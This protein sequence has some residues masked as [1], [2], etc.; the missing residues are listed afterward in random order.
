MEQ[1]QREKS[2]DDPF[3]QRKA[4]IPRPWLTQ[5]TNSGVDL[6]ILGERRWQFSLNKLSACCCGKKSNEN[7]TTP[8]APFSDFPLIRRD[9]RQSFNSYELYSTS[10][11]KSDGSGSVS[12]FTDSDT[13]SSYSSTSDEKTT[14]PPLVAQTAPESVS[15]KPSTIDVATR[16]TSL[17]PLN[18][19]T[20]NH[21]LPSSFQP[22]SP[23]Q[24]LDTD[25]TATSNTS[26][27]RRLE[28]FDF[29]Q[30]SLTDIWQ[31][32]GLASKLKSPPPLEVRF[33][34]DYD[35]I[36]MSERSVTSDLDDLTGFESS[37][38]GADG[39]TNDSIGDGKRRSLLEDLSLLPPRPAIRR[40]KGKKK[41]PKPIMSIPLYLRKHASLDAAVQGELMLSGWVAASLDNEAFELTLK[42]AS[43]KIAIRNV[44]YMQIV[45]ENMTA[46]V[47]LYDTGGNVTRTIVLE[48]DWSCESHEITGRI[49]KCVTIKSPSSTIVRILPISLDDSFFDGEDLVPAKEFAQLQNKLFAGGRGKVYAPDEQHD[50]AT[51]ILFSL[52]ALIKKW[53]K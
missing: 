45:Q 18:P 41:K 11:M 48:H 6:D 46:S 20:P 14:S 51:Y 2:N 10:P 16:S 22:P 17:P 40:S 34:D 13:S 36:R 3:M 26:K 12:D 53:G 1:N 27:H 32:P 8:S 23:R 39:T 37:H 31:D 50:A 15:S 35:F 5:E 24:R 9:S 4:P 25:H 7:K 52:D 30:Q 29:S 43:S 21:A 49:G 47:I 33:P 44:H 42:A 38:N 19:T 28:Q